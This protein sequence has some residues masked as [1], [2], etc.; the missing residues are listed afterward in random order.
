[1]AAQSG[2]SKVTFMVDV[3]CVH[4]GEGDE[5]RVMGDCVA[6]GDLGEAGAVALIT[7]D[8][9]FPTYVSPLPVVVTRG[10]PVRYRCASVCVHMHVCACCCL[11]APARMFCLRWGVR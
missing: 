7:S 8:A 5:V 3:P 10:Y 4:R 6:L 1:M 9:T 11:C 2:Q